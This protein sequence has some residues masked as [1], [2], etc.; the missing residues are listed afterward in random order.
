MWNDQAILVGEKWEQQIMRSITESDIGLLL[1]S[2]AFLTSKYITDT[3]LTRFIGDESKPVIPVEVEA[4]GFAKQDLKGLQHYQLFRLDRHR[5]FA[6]CTGS[7]LRRF[8]EK[9]YEQVERRL[10]RLGR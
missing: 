9:L 10:D 2:P 5:S 7:N 8:A 3:E 1:V 6:M 4:V